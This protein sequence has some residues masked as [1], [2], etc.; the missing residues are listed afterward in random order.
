MLI[1]RH[2]SI[3]LVLEQRHSG[4]WGCVKL[5]CMIA[6]LP[7]YQRPQL[8]AAHD[9]YWALIRQ[10][11]AARGIDSPERLAQQVPPDTV[12]SDLGLV[13]SQT[14]GLPY[15]TELHNGLGF[16]TGPNRRPDCPILPPLALNALRFLRL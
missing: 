4:C 5:R 10:Q 8:A 9:R 6:S 3:N 13:L 1:K 14:C 2:E 7:M 15:R 11:L 16:S 12:W